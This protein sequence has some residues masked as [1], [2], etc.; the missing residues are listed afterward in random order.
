MR[1]RLH[2]EERKDFD[3]HHERQNADGDTRRHEQLEE[4]QAVLVEAVEKHDEEHQ[5][6]QRSGDDDVA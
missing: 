3:Q 2:E 6:R 5:Q 1:N 4:F